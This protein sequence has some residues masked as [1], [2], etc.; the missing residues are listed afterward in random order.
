MTRNTR[1][2]RIAPLL[3]RDDGIAL[4]MVLV[5]FLVGVALISAFLVAITGSSKVTVTSRDTVR[6]QAAAEAGVADVL[7]RMADPATTFCSLASTTF[8]DP[9]GVVAYGAT[10]TFGDVGSTAMPTSWTSTCPTDTTLVR[11]L[12]SGTSGGSTQT[13]ERIHEL[14]VVEEAEGFSSL[15]YTG[16]DWIFQGGSDFH[17]VDPAF[18]ADVTIAEGDFTCNGSATIDGSVSVKDGNMLMNGGCKILGNVEVSGNLVRTNGR[19][20]GDAVVA[21]S[22]QFSG[23]APAVDGSLTHGGALTW[24]WGNISAW[25]KG[26]VNQT[27]VTLAPAEPWK[28]LTPASFPSPTWDTIPWSGP[29]TIPNSG[30]ASHPMV[31]ILAGLTK[32][33]LIDARTT[34]ATVP[35]RIRSNVP[36]KL[37]D[38]VAFIAPKFHLENFEFGSTTTD[39]RYLYVVSDGTA[40]PAPTCVDNASDDDIFVAGVR[41]T[42]L[43]V[44]GLLY[45]PNCVEIDDWGTGH[46]HGAVYSKKFSKKPLLTYVQLPDPSDIEGGG[47]G[48]P[49][50]LMLEPTPVV[51]RNV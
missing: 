44:A 12:S 2:T 15:I 26:A 22:V 13:I 32:P 18:P 33:T 9:S 34:C 43:K 49:G 23:G 30:A 25:V 20:Y 6:A 45:G 46:W 29:C 7:G 3:R 31:A 11:I 47:G 42:D 40:S 21:G 48:T 14:T 4:P 37:G 24:A 51:V 10:V 8:S 50:D 28:D 36:L 1:G 27:P 35:V 5:V 16:G 17:P 39:Q 38:D 41:F 19:I